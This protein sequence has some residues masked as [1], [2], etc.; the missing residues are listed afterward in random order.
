MKIAGAEGL[1]EPK[2]WMEDL[3]S[4]DEDELNLKGI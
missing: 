2:N 4:V 3:H 1:K